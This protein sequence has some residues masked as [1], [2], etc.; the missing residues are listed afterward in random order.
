MTTVNDIYSY[1]KTLAPLAL[2]MDFDNSGLQIGRTDAEVTRAVL[3][4]DITGEVVD[5]AVDCG[6]QLIISHHP[7]IFTPLKSIS[8]DSPT[9]EKLLRL[10]EN[11]V[12]A[13]SMHTNLDIADGG[14]ND[15]LIRLLGAEPEAVLDA[16]GC[17]RVGTLPEEIDLTELLARCKRVLHTS[18][19]RYLDCGRRVR[20]IA[21]TGGSGGG[22]IADA[23][24][25]G[26]DCY[27][28]AD[29]KYHQFLEA[30]ELGLSLIDGDHFGTEDPVI[31]ALAAK[32][33]ERFGDIEFI[34][35][36]RH[37]QMISFF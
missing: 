17:G 31:P 19:L 11:R 37:G 18:A 4:L 20:R 6:A 10:A 36:K 25:L 21:V 5:E 32:L 13:I 1:L 16:D 23:V 33:R 8:A 35:S 28:T 14:V 24:R 9:G 29:I 12:A 15:V 34:V 30:K 27:I 22:A 3:A 2:Q 7:L 26:C